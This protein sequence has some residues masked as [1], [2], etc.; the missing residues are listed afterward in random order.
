[1]KKRI[2]YGMKIILILEDLI[3]AMGRFVFYSK[4]YLAKTKHYTEN[5]GEFGEKV[6]SIDGL[7]RALGVGRKLIYDW[8]KD[9]DKVE[10]SLALDSLREKIIEMN[11]NVH[12]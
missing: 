8:E 10:F 7:A 12:C 1:L 3:M 5:F 6:P 4:E 11:K 9:P 2:V